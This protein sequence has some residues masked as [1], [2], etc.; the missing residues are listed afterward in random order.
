[1]KQFGATL[2]LCVGMAFSSMG[3]SSDAATD[4]TGDPGTSTESLE[5]FSWWVAPGES[6]ALRALVTQF[7]TDYPGS[8]VS[9]K[10]EPTAANWQ[11]LLGADIDASPWD[12]VQISGS[13]LAKFTAD[14]PGALAPL[15]EFYDEP[16]LKANVIPDILKSVTVDGHPYGI[17]TGVHRNNSFMYGQGVFDEQGLEPPKTVEEFLAACA[18][19]KAAGITPLATSYETW[20]LRIVFDEILAGTLGAETFDAFLKGEK[21]ASDPEVKAGLESAIAAFGKVLQN[22]VDRDRAAV[23]GYSWTNAATDLKD[24]RAAMLMHGDWAKG[25]VI[26]LGWKAG[27]DFGVSGPPGASDLF[28]YGADTFALPSSAPHEKLGKEFLT[29]VASKEGQIEFNLNKGATPMRKDVADQLDEPGQVN[30]NDLVNAAVRMPGHAN[31]AWD[32]GIDKFKVDF[33][34]AKLLEVYMTAAP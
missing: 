34:E 17:V 10:S 25:Y 12:A 2:A 1:M 22:Y 19:L 28:I 20:A 9:Q 5:L 18:A 4:G 32:A 23:D 13:D 15:D 31:D 21:P 3:C 30:L 16:S 26:K 11:M 27:I 7:K 24:G 29:V 6:D 14:H 33:D 8:R